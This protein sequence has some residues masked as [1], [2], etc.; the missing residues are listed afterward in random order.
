MKIFISYSSH[1]LKLA[2]RV[3]GELVR[4]G[5]DAFQFG[6]SEVIG[7]PSWEQ[8]LDWISQCDV[9]IVLISKHAVVSKPVREE[10]DQAHYSYINSNHPEKLVPAV[11]ERGVQPPRLIERFARADLVDYES[12]M[13]RLMDQLGL[14]RRSVSLLRDTRNTSLPDVSHLFSE[15]KKKNPIPSVASMFSSQAE[16]I[17]ANYDA[18]K[19]SSIQGPQKARHIDDILA[20]FSGTAPSKTTPTTKFDKLFLGYEPSD[21]SATRPKLAESLLNWNSS[22]FELDPPTLQL[23]GLTLEWTEVAGALG[24]ALEGSVKP[25]FS[26]A[27]ELC[28]GPE[29]THMPMFFGVAAP[30]HFRVKA[31]GGVFATDSRW[32]QTVSRADVGLSPHMFPTLYKGRLSAPVLKLMMPSVPSPSW[33]TVADASKYVLERDDIGLFFAAEKIYEGSAT[34][35]FDWAAISAKLSKAYYRVKAV[36]DL[37][38]ADSKWSDVVSWTK[39]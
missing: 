19:P 12:G 32:S 36:G 39:G 13:I 9:F 18:V 34:I 33:S 23:S 7:K 1:D 30:K 25:D 11:I 5:A 31:I 26:D 35:H 28:R 27:K 20:E 15:Y 3:F 17:V 14:V 22:L 4:G 38:R 21:P 2:E 8:V 24:Y 6:K 10:I 16:Q 29:R 37:T